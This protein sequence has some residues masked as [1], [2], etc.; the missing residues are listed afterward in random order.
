MDIAISNPSINSRSPLKVVGSVALGAAIAAGAPALLGHM[1][2]AAL[3]RDMVNTFLAVP[4]AFM[5]VVTPPLAYAQIIADRA[6]VDGCAIATLAAA[7]VYPA[8]LVLR[9]IIEG[10]G[11]DASAL[12][13][14][15]PRGSRRIAAVSALA[16]VASLAL[17]VSCDIMLARHA[18]EDGLAWG[19]ASFVMIWSLSIV[20]ASVI[21]CLCKGFMVLSS[22]DSDDA[23]LLG[24]ADDVLATASA[25]PL[26]LFFAELLACVAAPL[27]ATA[28]ILRIVIR[29][30][31]FVTPIVIN[32]LLFIGQVF[33]LFLRLFSAFLM[34]FL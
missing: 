22:A 3:W 16:L 15:G 7:L 18:V 14:F 25:H 34:L 24:V 26:L 17:S 32:V 11:G 6:T 5:G 10:F 30:I 8:H 33:C 13:T 20:P 21:V 12:L 23:G 31:I 1:A 4:R 19:A 27:A 2:S 9:W 28:V 29:A